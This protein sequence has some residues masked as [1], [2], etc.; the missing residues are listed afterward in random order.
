[1]NIQQIESYL[2]GLRKEQI[3]TENECYYLDKH[4]TNTWFCYLDFV[5][6]ED[7]DWTKRVNIDW[8]NSLNEL[9]IK[10][11]YMRYWYSESKKKRLTTIFKKV[12]KYFDLLDN[13]LN[14]IK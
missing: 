4:F 12:F 14:N 11:T 10:K 9:L 1:M 2:Q 13:M 6:L 7:Y 8:M 5:I 3:L